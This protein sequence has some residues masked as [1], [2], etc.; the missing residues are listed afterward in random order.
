MLE[1]AGYP[2][3]KVVFDPTIARGLDYYTG[4]IYETTLKDVP[5]LGSVCSGGRYDNLVKAL[6]GPDMPA[7]GTSIGVD[8]LFDGL[9][10][11]GKLKEARTTTEVLVTNFGAEHTPDYM[12]VARALRDAGFASEVYYDPDKIGKQLKFANK[13]RIPY[14]VIMGPQ[15]AQ[16]GV[17]VIKSLETGEQIEVP[18]DRLSDAIAELRDQNNQ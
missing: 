6:G 14:V 12:R 8:R 7:V 16:N 11:L 1:G 2:L 10:Q 15:E 5:Q 18:I 3:D 13:M 17:G 4:I 9:Q